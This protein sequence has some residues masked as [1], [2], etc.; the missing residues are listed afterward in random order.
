MDE[1]TFN[2]NFCAVTGA[3]LNSAHAP[4]LRPC[5]RTCHLP[6][7][8]NYSFIRC[9]ELEP[10]IPICRPGRRQQNL[11]P[12][13]ALILLRRNRRRLHQHVLQMD[14]C[15]TAVIHIRG[16]VKSVGIPKCRE[17]HW[18]RRR[19]TA[20]CIRVQKLSYAVASTLLSQTQPCSENPTL[21]PAEVILLFVG[22]LSTMPPRIPGKF[23]VR[24]PHPI[25]VKRED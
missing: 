11:A 8:F 13:A 24:M 15:R 18:K 6:S 12:F 3:K 19:Q 10:A 9:T 23:Q 20:R 14:H 16:M 5:V 17:P 4:M 1:R 25:A 7:A 21:K 22:Q 2:L